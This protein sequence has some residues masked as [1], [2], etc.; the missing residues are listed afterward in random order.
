VRPVDR[1]LAARMVKRARRQLL[2][3]IELTF[4]HPRDGK[5]MNFKSDLPEDMAT[6]LKGLRQ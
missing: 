5:T 2:H 1:P 6:V 3:A 4:V